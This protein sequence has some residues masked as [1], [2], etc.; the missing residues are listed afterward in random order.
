MLI[1]YLFGRWRLELHEFEYSRI[2]DD[3]I[4]LLKKYKDWFQCVRGIQM[5][6]IMMMSLLILIQIQLIVCSQQFPFSQSDSR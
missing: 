4:E 5:M 2:G 3:T 1:H 6:M